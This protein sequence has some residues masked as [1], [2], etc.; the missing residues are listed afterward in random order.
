MDSHASSY[1]FPVSPLP[2]SIEERGKAEAE[3]EAKEK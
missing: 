2:S 1:P 3:A